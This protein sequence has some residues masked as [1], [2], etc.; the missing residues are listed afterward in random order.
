MAAVDGMSLNQ[1]TLGVVW[2][3]K[4]WSTLKPLLAVRM[5]GWSALAERPRAV[6]PERHPPGGERAGDAGRDAAEAGVV[7]RAAA[8]RSPR[9]SR[10]AS[11]AG[12][13]SRPSIVVTLP[14]AVRIT[15]NPP[16]PMPQEYGS[17]TPSTL[18]AATAAST[19]L[20]PSRSAWIAARVPSMSTDAAAPPLPAAV[21]C[22][23]SWASAAGGSRMT[24]ATSATMRRR[25]RSAR[26]AIGIARWLPGAAL[27]DNPA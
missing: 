9:T 18:A 10:A 13:S 15:M 6:A 23:W 12:D 22:F 26:R 2:S 4:V 20:P 1:S 5:P 16:P 27:A 25:A 24:S 21:G 7:E 8:R 14:P 17:V 19:A 3:K 11:S